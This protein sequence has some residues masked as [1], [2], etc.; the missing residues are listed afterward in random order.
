MTT[1]KLI[2]PLI[3][4]NIRLIKDSLSFLAP[5]LVGLLVY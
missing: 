3:M 4:V 5:R 1:I 2:L